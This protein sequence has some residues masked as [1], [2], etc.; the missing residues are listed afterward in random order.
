MLQH[1]VYVE[2]NR[3]LVSNL[4]SLVQSLVS[5]ICW[6]Q[7]F[8]SKVLHS[9]IHRLRRKHIRTMNVEVRRRLFQTAN[10]NLN[11]VIKFFPVYYFYSKISSFKPVLSIKIALNSFYLLIFYSENFSIWRLSFSVDETLNLSNIFTK[12]YFVLKA[13]NCT[14]Q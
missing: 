7:G 6:M 13:G 3:E 9:L 10:V 14:R 2:K 1:A 11:H 8:S 12:V 4:L 5:W